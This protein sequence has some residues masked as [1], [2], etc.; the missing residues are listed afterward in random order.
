MTTSLYGI[1]RL[2]RGAGLADAQLVTG[3]PDAEVTGV[4]GYTQERDRAPALAARAGDLVVVLGRPPAAGW[5]MDALLRRCGELGAAGLLLTDPED[6][7]Q[8]GRRVAERLGLGVLACRDVW[9][10]SAIC[11]AELA[12]GA[13]ARTGR[14]VAQALGVE[15][16]AGPG[17]DDLFAAF[18]AAFGTEIV[19]LDRSGR[20]LAGATG[21][22]SANE[23]R[24]IAHLVSRTGAGRVTLPS[25]RTAAASPVRPIEGAGH[26]TMWLAAI[27]PGGADEDTQATTV[28]VEVAATG[29]VSRLAARRLRDERD[30]RTRTT[31]LA[32]LIEAA[33]DPPAPLVRRALA[34]GWNINGHHLGIRLR[35]RGDVDALGRR[36]EVLGAFAEE[37]LRLVA[38][39]QDEGWAAWT[40]FDT[41][42]PA[43][44]VE[45]TGRAVRRA[46]HRLEPV[47]PVAVGVGRLRPGP[48]GLIATL[49]EA[50]D[51][52]TIA[53]GRPQTGYV[54]EVDRLGVAQLLLALTESALF[55]P[56]ARGLLEPLGGPASP[57]A[58]T[59]RAYLDA[60]G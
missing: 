49:S 7:D 10:A 3:R 17:L 5:A 46:A 57:L 42:P 33:A 53:L 58:T 8:A 30:A 51:A 44:E 36:G 40:S 59:L 56:A 47:L 54:V 50:G 4:L 6:I 32:D 9:R 19:L 21:A 24:A 18:G 14:L 29:A 45:A 38:V 35:P 26:A 37:G 48:A 27:V 20:P 12:G 52:A 34:A 15:A 22:L 2:L 28:I 31:L 43:S 60:N 55:A 25:G 23:A 39:E 16:Q 11:F 13:D 41:E 1:V